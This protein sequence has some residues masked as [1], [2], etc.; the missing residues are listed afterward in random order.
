MLS[1]RVKLVKFG[2][3]KVD[4]EGEDTEMPIN[5]GGHCESQIGGIAHTEPQGNFVT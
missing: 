4:K 3:G 5:D 1:H 2:Y